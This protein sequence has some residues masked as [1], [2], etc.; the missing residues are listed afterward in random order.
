MI[1]QITFS[2]LFLCL[3]QFCLAQTAITGTWKT[4]DDD[5]GEEKSHIKIEVKDGKY[6]GTVTEI[7]TRNKKA[8]CSKCDGIRK[9]QPI[10]GMMLLENLEPYKDYYSYGTIIDPNNGKKYK[11]SVWLDNDNTLI[12]RG[13]VGI[14]ALGRSQKWE[15]VNN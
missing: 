4:I 9:N 1:K 13:Y 11:C 7:L 15:R 2:V 6:Y 8:I 12:V 10:E 3:A 14:S 5:S